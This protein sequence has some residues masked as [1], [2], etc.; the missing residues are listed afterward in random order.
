M[1]LQ[2]FLSIWC[3]LVVPCFLDDHETMR[4]ILRIALNQP[5]KLMGIG[6]DVWS[7]QTP[8]HAH[9]FFLPIISC[10]IWL[11]RSFEKLTVLTAISYI[12]NSMF[13]NTRSW[14]CIMLSSVVAVFEAPGQGLTETTY[15]HVETCE[16]NFCRLLSKEKVLRIQALFDFPLSWLG[17]F[18]IEQS[19]FV[20]HFLYPYVKRQTNRVIRSGGRRHLAYTLFPH[21]HFP[22]Q[23][24][25]IEY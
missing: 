23:R 18:V 10:S 15:D 20:V 8:A 21:T 4:N 13:P 5:Q 3:V 2:L 7:K 9:K 1:L 22:L 19:F 16:T 14:T 17:T 11:T 25:Y 24:K 12:F 6:L